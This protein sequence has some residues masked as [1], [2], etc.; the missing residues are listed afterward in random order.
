MSATMKRAL[1]VEIVLLRRHLAVVSFAVGVR[2]RVV[3]AIAANGEL[4]AMRF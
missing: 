4:G 2:A 3:E 1:A